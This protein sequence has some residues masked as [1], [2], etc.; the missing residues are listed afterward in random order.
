MS[1]EK[2]ES[3]PLVSRDSLCRRLSRGLEARARFVESHINKGLAYQLRAM[4]EARQW[5]QG[6][7]ATQVNMPQAAISRLESTSYGKPTI[8]TLKRMAK[9]Y[10]VALEVRFV[11]FSKFLNRISRTPYVEQGL[12]SDG[13]DVPSFEE[14]EGQGAFLRAPSQYADYELGREQFVERAVPPQAMGIPNSTQA[15]L[16]WIEK[17]NGLQR[18]SS[19]LGAVQEKK[20]ET[21]SEHNTSRVQGELAYAACFG[22]T[23]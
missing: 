15:E 14:E 9:V 19:Y 16:P 6:D 5:S 17:V 1:E 18:P 7:L 12:S 20:K 21:A 8:T 22:A 3:T 23:G 4:R 10:D 11:P 2:L 13:L